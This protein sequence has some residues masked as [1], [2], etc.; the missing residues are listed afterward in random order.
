M[1]NK[2]NE[3]YL[4]KC[5]TISIPYRKKQRDIDYVVTGV[6]GNTS[7]LEVRLKSKKHPCEIPNM[8]I[9]EMKIHK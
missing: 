6:F 4:T 2:I 1:D 9:I 7:Y 5:I 8:G 3:L